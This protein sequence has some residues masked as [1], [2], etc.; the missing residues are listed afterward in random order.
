MHRIEVQ[1][2]K[3]FKGAYKNV[4]AVVLENETL[5]VTVTPYHGA[6]TA[7]IIY[8]PL[9][10]EL[11]WQN[12]DKV[13]A[14]PPYGAGYGEGEFAGFDEMFPTISRCFYEKAP[15][16]GIEV[17]DHGEVWAL[18]WSF[19][20]EDEEVLLSVGGVRFPYRLEKRV[21]LKE[22]RLRNSYRLENLSSHPFS[23]IWAA[24]PLFNAEEGME[25]LVPSGM[26]NIINSVAG[27][28]LGAYGKSYS[29]PTARLAS[30]EGFDFSRMPARNKTGYQK[31]YFE[32]KVREGWALLYNPRKELNIGL[33]FPKEE[34]PFLG[35][36]LNEGGFD[37]QYNI[38]PEPATAAM[39]RIDFSEM[40]GAGSVIRGGE[41]KTWHLDI[42]AGHGKK[43]FRM[44]EAGAFSFQE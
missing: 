37:G 2:M 34:V 10:L 43:A 14:Q 21:S 41:V 28:R 17:P 31:Y 12:P 16:S 11:L 4:E 33:S 20:M 26:E 44:D 38:A 36:W 32:G 40:W 25:F 22:G 13:H 9:D 18:P 8:K 35:M 42:T 24:H 19:R 15:W 6:R 27:E 30:G 29:F 1:M 7:S 23:Y 5:R 39:D 3:I